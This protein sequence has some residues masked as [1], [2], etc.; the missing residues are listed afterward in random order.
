MKLTLFVVL[1]STIQILANSVYSQSTKFTL[2]RE[3]VTIENVLGTIEDQSEFY[4]LY[5]G[6][7]V[8]V[9]Q[10]VNIKVEKQNL[11]NTL[12]E[13]LR[14]TN[15]TYKI[16]DRQV[17]LSPVGA[18]ETIQQ[19][20]S[21][22][23]K[24][25]DSTGSPLPGVSVVVKGTTNGTITDADGNYSLPNVPEN[26]TLQFSFVGMKAQEV[27][28][29]GKSTINLKMEEDAIG[30]EE[31]VAI[32]YGTVK[33]SNL[34]SSVSK[35]DDNAIKSRPITTIGEAFAGQL[36][37]VRAQDATGIPGAELIIRIRGINTINGN[38]SPLYVIDGIPRDNMTD[39]NPSDVASIQ[40]LKDASATSIYGSRGGNGVILIETK[41][42]AGNAITTIDAYYGMQ[43]PVKMMDF[44]NDAEY[45][46]YNTFLRNDGYIRTGGSMKDPM[47]KRPANLQIPTSWNDGSRPY[48]DWQDA[49]MQTAPINNYQI[50]SSWGSDKGS[51]YISGGF[52]DQKGIIMETYYNR[53]NFRVNSTLNVGKKIKLGVNI[54]PSYSKQADQDT[55]GKDTN[56]HTA[57]M[58]PPLIQLWENTVA[59]GYPKSEF[60]VAYTNPYEKIKTMTDDTEKAKLLSSIW[61]EYQIIKGLTFKSL[62]SHDYRVN[63]YEY[64]MPDHIKLNSFPEGNSNTSR[65][66]DWTFQ[67]TLTYD[68]TV[69]KD[70]AINLLLGQSADEHTFYNISASATGFPNNLVRTLNVAATPTQAYTFK[71][72]STTASYFGRV[73]YN[74][75]DKYL[76]NA[77]VRRDGSSRFGGNNKWGTFPSVSAGW[78]L[79][80]E[81]FMNGFDWLSLLKLRLSWGMAGNDRIGNYDYMSLLTVDNTA[82]NNTI[83]VGL[84]PNNIGNQDLKWETTETTNFG[85]DLSAFKNRVQL[86]LD[87]YINKT[88]DLLF[89][90]PVPFASGFSSIR[91]N[92][93]EVENKGWEIDLTT[94][95]TSGKFR[96]TSSLNL[97]HN[98]NK[99]IDMGGVK[100][101]IS[102][103]WDGQFLTRVGGPVSQFFVYRTDGILLPTD[104]DD[105]NKALVP[106][107]PGQIAGNTKYVDQLTIDSNG[108]GI[109]DKADGVIN[110]SDF[111][112]YGSNLPDLMYGF[113]N[114]FEYKGF[115]LSVLLQGQFGGEVLFLGSRQMDIGLFE[116]NQLKRW[117]RSWKPDYEAIYGEGENPI[118]SIPGVDMSW[119]G[120]TP[121]SLA[122]KNENNSDLRIYDAT[123]FKIKNISLTYNFPK[124]ILGKS[125]LKA[126]KAYISVDNL[127]TF[128]NNYPGVTTETNTF[129]NDAT[130]LGVDYTTYPLS[131]RYTL[132]VNLTF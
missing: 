33:K 45:V 6:K 26:T 16:Y 124:S 120:I 57:L 116:A 74:Y 130:Q 89:N 60:R 131:K 94:V 122:G 81:S 96:W 113:T 36:A 48:V 59:G 43:E 129:G 32:G 102:T 28:V 72:R 30:I 39:I 87:Y 44:M 4:F 127:A 109:M 35:I 68:F 13:L 108:D 67:N 58:M 49:I 85:V 80:E 52:L 20:K 69:A 56:L 97:S 101:F 79:N 115:E 40:V 119:D 82:W 75:K 27:L 70:H 90:T 110:S 61:G 105:K 15:I 107:V 104:F 25:T 10:K 125:L 84:A 47:S 51:I 37:G 95:N 78:K 18:V 55:Q 9:T 112:P 132:G 92:L 71:D 41:Q 38:S 53:M 100:Q 77:T 29:A 117:V 19:Q 31:V 34:T 128:D 65:W 23:G 3:N 106:I 7:L 42:G 93:G 118:P 21:V 63:I 123:F 114:R 54:T 11:E 8:D 5:N 46:A 24:V 62:Y 86:N 1:L 12:N 88:K 83:Q 17:V 121:F 2:A 50:S 66:I 99:V 22:S 64:F 111:T 91:T 76:L 98:Q 126:A 103:N 14:N 73:S